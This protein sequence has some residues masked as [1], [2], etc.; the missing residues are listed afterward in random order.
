MSDSLAFFVPGIAA[1]QGSK[2][3]VG[4]GRMV[5]SSKA[6]APWRDSVHFHAA[7]AARLAGWQCATTA[8]SAGMVFYFPRPASVSVKRRPFPSVKPDLSK[9]VRAVEDALTTAGVIQDDALIVRY[10]DLEMLYAELGQ[11]AGVSIELKP[12]EAAA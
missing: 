11:P 6:L 5:E 4:H 12:R 9:I 1:P 10:H 3:H 2:R 8:L 7:Q